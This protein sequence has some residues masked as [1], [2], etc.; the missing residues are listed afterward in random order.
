M[1]EA[2]KNCVKYTMFG[3]NLIFF[4]CG[5]GLIAAG[6]V[7]QVK[8]TGYTHFFDYGL[9]VP[10]FLIIIGVFIMAISFLGCCGAARDNYYM[11]MGFAILVGLIF[12]C[13]VSGGIAGY[14][15]RGKVE[16]A[17]RTG[18]E[19]EI[20]NILNNPDKFKDIAKIIDEVQK[21]ENCCGSNNFADW[22]KNK[23]IEDYTIPESCCKNVTNPACDRSNKTITENCAKDKDN[24]NCPVRSQGCAGPTS[25]IM[26]KALDGAA[27]AALGLAIIELIGFIFACYLA[28]RIRSGYTYA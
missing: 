25:S 5:I 20:D 1:G 22:R 10:V 16:K 7:A 23:T 27:G 8:Y 13:Q 19:R 12:V 24:V 3:F 21:E 14:V 18:L 26:K 4:V 17:I 28:K 15:Q 9:T 6:G 2:T 11:L